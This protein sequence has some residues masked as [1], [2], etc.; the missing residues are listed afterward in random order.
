VLDRV[1]LPAEIPAAGADWDGWTTGHPLF[2][3][4]RL[5]PVNA[6]G[7]T[8]LFETERGR[9]SLLEN[10]ALHASRNINGIMYCAIHDDGEIALFRIE[11][12]D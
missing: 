3:E 1:E 5:I 8:L 12:A 10:D 9:V 11:E 4:E 6:K 7:G 2:R